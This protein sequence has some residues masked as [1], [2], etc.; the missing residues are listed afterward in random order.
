MVSTEELQEIVTDV[1]VC[2]DVR[3]QISDE[4]A[5]ISNVNTLI[6]IREI[7]KE[8]RKSEEAKNDK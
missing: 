2:H 5:H 3:Q 1:I 7:C 8:L 4:V 6:T